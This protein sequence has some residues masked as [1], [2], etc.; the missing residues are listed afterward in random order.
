MIFDRAQTIRKVSSQ[1]FIVHRNTAFCT[2]ASFK[3]KC[4]WQS[5][6]LLVSKL[7]R[8]FPEQGVR[9]L[10]EKVSKFVLHTRK[11]VTA[12]EQQA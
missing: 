10:K 4:P 6:V 3:D 2:E 8:R 11:K 12:L 7:L 1:V 9:L 5:R